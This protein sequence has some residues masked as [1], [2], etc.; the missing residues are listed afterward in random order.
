M[1]KPLDAASAR[2]F[3]A[4]P[5]VKAMLDSFGPVDPGAYARLAG[6]ATPP[7]VPRYVTHVE[8]YVPPSPEQA[9]LDAYL[10]I[11]RR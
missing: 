8:S 4:Q 9:L 10:P 11:P 7:E 2:A 1:P 5:H 3:M 6:G